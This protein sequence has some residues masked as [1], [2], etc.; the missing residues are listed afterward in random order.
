MIHFTDNEVHESFEYWLSYECATWEQDIREA[1]PILAMAILSR[2]INL[3]STQE[4]RRSQTLLVCDEHSLDVDSSVM[5]IDEL[6]KFTVDTKAAI[7]E[8][9]NNGVI[10]EEEWEL[11]NDLTADEV[12]RAYRFRPEM[13][14]A[15]YWNAFK[16]SKERISFY[17]IAATMTPYMI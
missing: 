17:S 8:L 13:V 1:V 15:S 14:A 12:T 9:E 10:T 4:E 6:Y 16:P 11:M 5:F 7:Y 2:N 3:I